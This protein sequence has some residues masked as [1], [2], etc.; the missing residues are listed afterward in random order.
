MSAS[1][2]A[3]SSPPSLLSRCGSVGAGAE[4]NL[5]IPVPAQDAVR[6]EIRQRG[7]AVVGR[8]REG[9]LE[10]IVTSAVDRVGS[11]SL[12]S[13]AAH[14]QQ[15]TLRVFSRDSPQIRAETC[16]FVASLGP[17]PSSRLE[18]ERAIQ[19]AEEAVYRRQWQAAFDDYGRGARIF[20]G[21]HRARDAAAA[22]HAM[23]QIA[24]DDLRRKRDSYALAAAALAG[25]QDDEPVLGV[26]EVLLA[27]ALLELPASDAGLAL[28][29]QARL[30]SAAAHF[31]DPRDR[32]ELPRLWNLQ[33]FVQFQSNT[34]RAYRL[35]AAAADECS[36]LKD[37]ECFARSR[38][39]MAVV[40]EEQQSYTAALSDY[41]D[42]LKALDGGFY[43][44]LAADTSGNLGRLQAKIGLFSASEQ[45]QRAAMRLYGVV[46]D[47]EGARLSARSLGGLLL[48]V[49]SLDDAATYLQEVVSLDCRQLLN[50][51]R[52]APELKA[53]A[54]AQIPVDSAERMRC[55]QPVQ[56]GELNTDADI[57]VFH[58]LLDLSDAA[59]LAGETSGARRCLS[60]AGPYA[61]DARTQILLANAQGNLLLDQHSAQSARAAFARAIGLADSA[62]LG[63]TVEYRAEAELG[64]AQSGLVQGDRR[65]CATPRFSGS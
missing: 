4:L 11:I 13:Q 53:G 7:L 12:L 46:G 40:A 50:T 14:A 56:L 15:L 57:T 63:P 58:A 43:P 65:R 48:Q 52:A 26:R 24:Y 1:G 62:A 38:Q 33:G 37:L 31:K 47:C 55:R 64:I 22:R 54:P 51:A 8:L 59:L 18:A 25:A 6:I 60:L 2:R 39:N 10:H 45:A 28:G 16:V 9:P 30:D 34:E 41:E 23:A 19:A 35:F 44:D 49:G 5:R 3:M 29:V 17:S 20:D 61:I 32:R 42:A 36:R 21:L 27:K